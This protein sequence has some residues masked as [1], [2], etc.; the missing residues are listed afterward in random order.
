[1]NRSDA[2]GCGLLIGCILLI[3]AILAIPI[4]GQ[5]IHVADGFRDGQ[6]Q[7][8]S[9]R[10]IMVKTWEGELALE[11]M[12]IRVD[13]G[14]GASGGNAWGFTVDDS[15]A[16]IVAK[17]QNLSP[18]QRVRVHYKQQLTS[19]PWNGESKYRVERVEILEGKRCR[20]E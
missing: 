20:G 8:F 9:S 16:D 15:R 1:M 13:G 4:A 5:Y 12:R 2:E 18:S 6:I 19:L 11:G 14:G 10:G 17:I 7:R 3:L